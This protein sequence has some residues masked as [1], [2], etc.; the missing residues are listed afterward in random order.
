MSYCN[1]FV[2]SDC[3]IEGYTVSGILLSNSGISTDADKV[4]ANC[5]IFDIQNQEVDGTGIFAYNSNVKITGLNDIYNNDYGIMSLNNS[6]ISLYGIREAD[7][8]NETQ[9]I[10]DNNINQVYA[11]R[12]AFPYEVK[13]NAI[14]DEGNDCL[15]K[16]ETKENEPPY[17]V[18]YNYWGANFNPQEDLCPV[19]LFSWLPVWNLQVQSPAPG[20]DEQMFYASQ[21]LAESGNYTQAQTGYQQVV[22]TYPASKYSI[23]SLK[24]LFTIEES[25][26]NDYTSLK[27]Y[28]VGIVN[29]QPNDE[30]VRIADFLSNLCDIKLENYQTAIAW[31]ESVIQNPPSFADSLFAIIDLGS[32]YIQMENDSLKSAPV[33]SM[34]EYKPASRKQYSEYRDYLL[35]LLFK[36]DAITEENLLPSGTSQGI[37]N[38]LPNFPNPFSGQTTLGYRLEEDASVSINIYD[39]T[40]RLVKTF[41]EGLKEKGEHHLSFAAGNLAPGIYFCYISANG[42]TGDARKIA[43][44]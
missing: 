43:L 33:G 20:T 8:V 31:Y 4:I 12:G 14:Y 28:Y 35:S 29:Q 26:T 25:A 37:A 3:S 23:A 22:S 19:D 39:Y 44:Q 2:I 10:H 15:F 11:T 32:L 6:E 16:Y 38:L 34:A 5:Q 24:E 27:N 18:T 30:L 42:T 40:G 36:D 21:T 1:S 7:S 9:Q 41:A 17:D 13:W